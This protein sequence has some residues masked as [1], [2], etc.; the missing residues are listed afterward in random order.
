MGGFTD[1]RNQ[2]SCTACPLGFVAPVAATSVDQCTI[3]CPPGTQSSAS[4]CEPCSEGTF[5]PDG[6]RCRKCV[7]GTVSNGPGASS[8]VPCKPGERVVLG[9][10]LSVKSRCEQCPAGT[11]TFAAGALICRQNGNPCPRGYLQLSSGDCIRCPVDHYFDSTSDLC[12]PCEDGEGSAGGLPL[13]CASCKQIVRARIKDSR[14]F[15]DATGVVIVGEDD[16]SCPPGT[17]L[18]DRLGVCIACERGTFST[19]SNVNKCEVCP[20]GSVQPNF[21]GK[22]CIRCPTGTVPDEER[23]QC[24]VP[25]SNCPMGTDLIMISANTNGT[26][27]CQ[28]QDCDSR[29]T[30]VKSVESRTCGQCKRNEFMDAD[31]SC[32]LCPPNAISDGKFCAECPA[33]LVRDF[34]V[35]ACRGILAQNKGIVNGV[36]AVC[37]P[38]SFGQSLN[39]L[40]DHQC[41]QCP[42]GTYR[43]LTN[44]LSLASCYPSDEGCPDPAPCKKCPPNTITREPGATQCK[45]C[46]EGTFSYGLGETECLRKGALSEPIVFNDPF[47]NVNDFPFDSEEPSTEPDAVLDE[48]DDM[49]TSS[50]PEESQS[51]EI[52]PQ[53]TDEPIASSEELVL[54]VDDELFESPFPFE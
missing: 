4:G 43:D 7:T 16:S 32:N 15:T 30:N 24:V 19:T 3:A 6:K 35:C 38:G 22:S 39:E 48:R 17:R 47:G 28:S 14:C 45:P 26:V 12:V 40:E 46:P 41:V 21:R 9:F 2:L 42:A 52:D 25:Q 53:I 11:T 51:P 29:P 49:Q 37:P 5:S 31:M 8:C 33:G 23:V 18:D 10:D 13:S 36:C 34:D 20:M 1:A 44:D 50:A 27:V 54:L